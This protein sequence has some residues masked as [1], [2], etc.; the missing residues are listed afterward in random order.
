MKKWILFL[1]FVWSLFV[2]ALPAHAYLDPGSGSMAL[3]ALLGGLAA[4][5]VVVKLYWSR[6]MKFFGLK[7]NSEPEATDPS[8]TNLN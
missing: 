7:K 1:T 6:L 8:S 5:M 2:F 4:L 3:Q